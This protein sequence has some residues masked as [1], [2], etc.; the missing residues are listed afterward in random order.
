MP[1]SKTIIA[2]L[3]LSLIFLGATGM[4]AQAA[5]GTGPQLKPQTRLQTHQRAML[6]SGTAVATQTGTQLRTQQKLQQRLRIDQP[7]E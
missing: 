5:A 1:T 7:A 4:T 2:T 3:A 6:K